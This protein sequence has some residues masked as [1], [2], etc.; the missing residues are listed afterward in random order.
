MVLRNRENPARRVREGHARAALSEALERLDQ[1]N[2][3][4]NSEDCA[5]FPRQ[6][7]DQEKAVVQRMG[8]KMWVS[9]SDEVMALALVMG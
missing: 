6:T 9:D 5:R 8:L 2:F 1:E 7:Y 4:L 3:Y